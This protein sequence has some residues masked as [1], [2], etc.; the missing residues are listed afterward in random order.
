[1]AGGV[2]L[3]ASLLSRKLAR[4]RRFVGVLFLL[5]A[6]AA[7]C[8]YR[9][10]GIVSFPRLPHPLSDQPVRLSLVLPYGNLHVPHRISHA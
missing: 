10:P 8:C 6:A 9:F 4:A 3:H 1:M 5:N 2:W 7:R